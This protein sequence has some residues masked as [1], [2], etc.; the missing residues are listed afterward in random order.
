MSQPK[1]EEKP[2]EEKPKLWELCRDGE[3]KKVEKALRKASPFLLKK[4][5]GPGKKT[6]L[7]WAVLAKGKQGEATV[8]HLLNKPGVEV[9]ARQGG[10]GGLTAL[11]FAS[12]HSSSAVVL[13]L[14]KAD[15]LKVLGLDKEKQ[16]ALE[17]A[18]RAGHKKGVLN[19]LK[20]LGD[21]EKEE[22]AEDEQM[23]V[24]RE[25]A[26]LEENDVSV[27]RVAQQ[28]LTKYQGISNET[29]DTN[30]ST[31]D[32]LTK[33]K[34]LNK[35]DEEVVLEE[36]ATFWQLCRHGDVEGAKAALALGADVNTKEEDFPCLVVAVLFQN[37]EV[38]TLLL[39][40]PAIQVNQQDHTGGTALHATSAGTSV[41]LAR[42]LLNQPGVDFTARDKSGKTPL[43]RGVMQGT[44]EV[45]EAMV[46]H[47]GLQLELRDKF[48]LNIKDIAK[49]RET[50]EFG[51]SNTGSDML[52]LIQREEVKEFCKEQDSEA[53]IHPSLKKELGVLGA[54]L[55]KLETRLD[56]SEA[57]S[58]SSSMEQDDDTGVDENREGGGGQNLE[59][60]S[61]EEEK[62]ELERKHTERLQLALNAQE[63]K[64]EAL[65]RE[66]RGRVDQVAEEAEQMELEL[67][68]EMEERLER[69]KRE[70]QDKID[71]LMS[72]K[73]EKEQS[74]ARELKGK[75]EELE[76]SDREEVERILEENERENAEMISRHLDEDED[77]Y[78]GQHYQYD[79]DNFE[80][81][82]E[83]R[84][85]EA[86]ENQEPS[87]PECPVCYEPMSPPLHVYQCA[88]GHLVC[89]TCR[90][91]IVECPTRCGRPLLEDR[92]FGTEALIA[93]RMSWN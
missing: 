12:T 6:C 10:G 7:M 31:E 32:L 86:G 35:E 66:G 3:A 15:G 30:Q 20:E 41:S 76:K 80:T 5:W 71:E 67:K 69:V 90:P 52:A 16:T 64:R 18:T 54:E 8:K 84:K 79:D 14:L 59:P 58:Q 26:T 45:V 39:S 93:G 38:V 75:M 61:R 55:D 85:E 72:D 56:D 24:E 21:L 47:M 23:L 25:E 4:R 81:E 74:L 40:S 63:E 62:A 22:S 49:K 11:H 51:L 60:K 48:G 50:S 42:K 82:E 2:K 65:T 78:D 36:N 53:D 87:A 1:G 43:M 73:K 92:A 44:V 13:A 9:N 17:R 89:G 37:E 29:T 19:L 34:L 83:A 91:Q 70:F 28:I 27:E 68:R 77:V 57:A 33:Y 46:N 88:R